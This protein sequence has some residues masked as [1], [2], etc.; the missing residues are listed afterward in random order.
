MSKKRLAVIDRKYK[1]KVR[2]K[3]NAGE[4]ILEFIQNELIDDLDTELSVDMSL[5]QDR[6]LDSLNMVS[7]MNFLEK[8][9][10]IDINT[11]EVTLENL[12]SVQKMIEF[13]Q[14]KTV[15]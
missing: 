4:I 2:N 14:K 9:F 11:S 5:F 15:E 12:D 6:L 7:L 3:M 8:T 1:P 13:V 10:G